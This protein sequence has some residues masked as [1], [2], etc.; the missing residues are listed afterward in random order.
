MKTIVA[1]LAAAVLALATSGAAQAG[2]PGRSHDSHY[3]DRSRHDEHYRRDYDHYRD[4]GRYC[5]PCYEYPCYGEPCYE[6]S[7]YCEPSYCE[8]CYESSCYPYR[9]YDHFRRSRDYDRGHERE[10]GRSPRK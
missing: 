9:D 3:T 4:Y 1:T 10:R 2:Q 6:E 7:C 8:P 5:E